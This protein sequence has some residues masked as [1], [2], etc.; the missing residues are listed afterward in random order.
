[1]LTHLLLRLVVL[2]SYCW[3][4]ARPLRIRYLGALYHVMNRGDRQEDIY[5]DDKDRFCFLETLA[6]AC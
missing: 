3:I 6:Q 5:F 4:M 2:K 1:M